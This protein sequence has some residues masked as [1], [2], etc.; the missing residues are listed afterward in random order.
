[1]GFGDVW[2]DAPSLPPR[3]PVCTARAQSLIPCMGA[4]KRSNSPTP[5]LRLRWGIQAVYIQEGGQDEGAGR[6]GSRCAPHYVLTC[7]MGLYLP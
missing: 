1:M 5:S 7:E 4:L 6:S 3:W 2:G